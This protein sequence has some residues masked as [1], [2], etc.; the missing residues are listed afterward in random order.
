MRP[1]DGARDTALARPAPP[2]RRNPRFP[3]GTEYHQLG[4]DAHVWDEWYAHDPAPDFAAMR[5][6]GLTLVR[7]FVSWK[8]FEPQ[9]GRYSEEAAERLAAL[10]E[11][12]S[13][14]RL[15]IIVCLFADE[16]AAE[17]LDVVWGGTRDPRTDPYLIERE[18]ALATHLAERFRAEPALFG[19]ELANEAFCAGFTSTDALAAW[20]ER[21]R[22]AVRD[23]GS[24]H[25]VMLPVDPETLYHSA[26]VDAREAVETCEIA[27]TH[28]TAA[29]LTYA[30]EG[31]PGEGC[32][33]HVDSF[34]LR[35]ASRGAP[36]L[37]D[38]VGPRLPDLSL[39][40]E[41]AA[42][43][44]ALYSALMNGASG[45]LVRRWRDGDSEPREPFFADESESLVG[46]Q[47]AAGLPKPALRELEEFAG[48][49]GGLDLG[50]Y[51]RSPERGA[52]LLGAERRAPAGQ[53]ASLY[54]PRSCLAAYACAK[55]AHLGV[56]VAQEGDD[57]S[58]YSLL[59]VPSAF[60]LLD[61][62]W[63]YLMRWVGEGGS[64][65]MSY[66]GGEAHPAMRE[67][68]GVDHL[69]DTGA[70]DRLVC[71]VAQ[72]GVI[73][74]LRSFDLRVSAGSFALLGRGGATVVATDA[75]GSPLVTSNRYG[76]GSATYLAAPLER[77]VGQSGAWHPVPELKS[78]LSAVYRASALAAGCRP[79]LECDTPSVELC[80]LAGDDG[81]DLL[82]ALNR[83]GREV[84]ATVTA[85]RA[86]ESVCELTDTS[87]VK[88]A[89]TSF[90]MPLGP[91]AARV[92]RLCY[93]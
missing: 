19:W 90:G 15:R 29:Y 4:P 41:A 69:G 36:V 70:G 23:G 45:A 11:S 82:L 31:P 20:V 39:A 46:L 25:P 93:V 76:R 81:E 87:P 34:L 54:T 71:R 28:A 62:T 44:C 8:F 32:A 21:M 88:V 85:A 17:L 10:F 65:V 78:M 27:V 37:V 92:L 47:D 42:V 68:F 67:L 63:N 16:H 9:V 51:T 75:T 61:E 30:A 53:P 33:S 56:T 52:V 12:A 91:F 59:I 5:A 6:A 49:L 77:V 35:L 55:A 57:C 89:G 80:L 86:I 3:L 48:V 58:A 24:T 40:E 7:V 13:L 64:L 60:G 14:H 83:S 26:G 79:L 84:T 50:R 66:G 18:A 1:D 43:R 74:G 22:E 73:D 38:S 2:V 72:D